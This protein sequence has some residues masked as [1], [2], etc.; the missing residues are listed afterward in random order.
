MSTHKCATPD[1]PMWITGRAVYCRACA[2]ERLRVQRRNSQRK[3]RIATCQDGRRSNGKRLDER[4][5]P[6]Q[7][8]G[9]PVIDWVPM[10]PPRDGYCTKCRETR[11][12]AAN[13]DGIC[14]G[15]RDDAEAEK[16][17]KSAETFKVRSTKEGIK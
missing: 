4:G 17:K 9:R 8:L 11:L 1:C 12:S 5:I 10:P 15:C 3:H 16:R 14:D 7:P 2:T 13:V 6:R